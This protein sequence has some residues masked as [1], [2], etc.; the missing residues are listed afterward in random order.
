MRI[1][2]IGGSFDPIHSGH[3]AMARHVL[4][5][6]LVDQVWF[7]VA[8]VPPLK[9]RKVSDFSVRAELVERAI[10]YDRRMK[11]CTLE[12]ERQGTS[13]TI[14]TV[15][16]LKKRYPKD[17]FVWLIGNDQAAQL[18]AW[19]DMERLSKEITFYVFPRNGESVQCA[20]PYER[21]DMNLIDVS[22]SEIRC[23]HK[24][25]YLPK[26]VK[27]KIATDYLY[28]DTFAQ[29]QMSERRYQHS[30]SV[31]ML[32]VALAKV[33]HVS[34]Q[35]AYCAGI[36]HDICKEW[37][38]DRLAV[39]LKSLDPER[40]SEAPAIWHGYAGAYYVA[41]AFGIHDR[42]ITKAIYHHVK[43]SSDSRLTM[44]V[45]ISDKLDPS[46]GYDSSAT[47][48]LCKKNL[49]AGYEAVRCQQAEYLKKEKK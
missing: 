46:R 43:G 13:Y 14:D 9:N 36:L 29:A 12:A 38:K 33:H 26:A 18:H 41:K 1:A 6:H 27:Y 7:M 35:K 39:Y 24:L 48:S 44:I 23:G 34:V 21:M 15:D 22:S 8:Y 2:V 31:A 3:L 10:R 45:Y 25:W 5:H 11:V 32:C 30:K 47:I 42:M 49:Q 28:V 16:I 37:G 40:L 19:K 4:K 17:S 20:Y